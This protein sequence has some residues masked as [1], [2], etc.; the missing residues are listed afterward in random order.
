MIK[1][2]IFDRLKTNG[3]DGLADRIIVLGI[4]IG[5]FQH[6]KLRRSRRAAAR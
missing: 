6:L 5:Y 2:G 3:D 1:I 4:K